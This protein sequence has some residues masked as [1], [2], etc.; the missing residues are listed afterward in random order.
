M[1]HTDR[2]FSSKDL[3]CLSHDADFNIYIG[4]FRA[5]PARFRTACHT[6]KIC[7]RYVNARPSKRDGR[8]QMRDCVS[9]TSWVNQQS[10]ILACAYS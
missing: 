3:P 6:Q 10:A 9:L 7:A 1:A 4:H 8:V 2:V 5:M